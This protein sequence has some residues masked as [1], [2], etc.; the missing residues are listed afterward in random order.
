MNDID[1]M[2]RQE[3]AEFFAKMGEKKKMAK[4][5]VAKKM[6]EALEQRFISDIREELLQLV[7]GD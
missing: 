6:I 3:H 5:D 2:I 1:Q 7:K 4:S